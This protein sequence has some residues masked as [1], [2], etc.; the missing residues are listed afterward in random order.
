MYLCPTSVHPSFFSPRLFW[1]HF[2]RSWKP[3]VS[4]AMYFPSLK[5]ASR[6]FSSCVQHESELLHIS[7]SQKKLACVQSVTFYLQPPPTTTQP[8]REFDQFR[9][10]DFASNARAH[11]RN[12][13]CDLP[14]IC[15]LRPRQHPHPVLRSPYDIIARLWSGQRGPDPQSSTS[16][17]KPL[18]Q[19]AKCPSSIRG[20]FWLM[21][22]MQV[23]SHLVLRVCWCPCWCSWCCSN[24]SN[25]PK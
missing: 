8:D 22:F 4:S 3:L 14:I 21:G 24:Q 15:L 20:F 11:R 5:N 13:I 10:L 6:N 1:F 12:D 9:D 19:P 17:P 2:E 16:A 23:L 7:S 18:S 25:P